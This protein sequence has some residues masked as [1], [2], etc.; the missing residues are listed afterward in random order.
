M[1][2]L[3]IALTVVAGVAMGAINNVAGG[4]GIIG[5]LAFEYGFGLPLETANPSTRLAAVAIGAFACIGFVRAGRKIPKQAFTQALV[6]LPGALLGAK[7]AIGLPPM[8]FR[9][10]L[11]LIMVMLLVQMLRGIKPNAN[12]SPAWQGM[13]GCFLIGLHMGYAQVGTGL[14]ATL[15]LAKAYDRDLLAVNAAKCIVVTV[16]ALVS[17]VSL[18]I[19]GAITWAPAIALA[20]GCAVGSYLASH[21]SVKQGAGAVRKV[22]LLI[23]TLALLEQLRQIALLLAS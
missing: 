4:A 18:A 16:T 8:V 19:D 3:I 10:Y 20:I 5:L 7:L 22:I 11:A 13:V 23:A 21:W 9:S 1:E 14:V 17:T 12:K 2:L 6:A 15:M